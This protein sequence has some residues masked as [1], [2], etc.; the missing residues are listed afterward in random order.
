MK[1]S[2]FRFWT[3][4]VL[5]GL[6]G[7]VAWVVENMYLNVFI[8]KMFSASAADIS[9]MVALSAVSAAVT[10]LFIGALC[11]RIGKLR[12]VIGLGYITWGVTILAFGLIRTDILS[13]FAGSVAAINSLGVT[14]VIV[15]DCLMTFFGSS[16]NDAAYNAWLTE[17]GNENNRGKIEGVNAMMPLIAILV[18][19]GGFMGFNLDMIESWTTIFTIIGITVII[20]GVLCFLLIENPSKTVKTRDGYWSTL[21]YSFRFKAVKQNKLLY[22][23]LVGFALFGIS[24]QTFMPYLI[25]YYEKTLLMNNYVLIM[26][27]AII[28]ASVVTVFY[29]RLYDM[30]G[31]K[32]SIVPA[33]FMLLGGYIILFFTTTTIPVFIGSLLMMCGYL[34]GMAVFGAVIRAEIPENMAG[35]FQGVRII[36][37]VLVPGVIG[38]A[39][40]SAVLKDAEQVLGN[41]GT[42]S[43]IPNRNIWLAATLTLVIVFVYLYF[44]FRF[45]RNAKNP[46]LTDAGKDKKRISVD[47]HPKPQ[48]KRNLFKILRDNWTLNGAPICLPYPPQS[49]L[50]NFKGKIGKKLVYETIF[51]LP[52]NFIMDKTILHFGAVDQICEVF[53]NGKKIG[54]HLDGYLD[55]SFDITPFL[56]KENHLRVICTDKLDKKFP[57]GK[58]SKKRGGMWYTPVS[59]IWQDV[60][61]ENVPTNHIKSISLTPDLKGVKI[62]LSENISSFT[63]SLDGKTRKFSGSTGYLEVENPHF[64]TP[65]D[66]YLY[67]ITVTANEDK[68]ESY[69]ALRK[70]EIKGDKLLLN[71]KPIFLHGVLDQGYYPDGIFLPAENEE[72]LRDIL[73][74]KELGFNTLRKHIKIEP[75]Q[76]YYYC[77]K[78]GML[79]LQD[80]VNSGGYSFFFDTALPTIGLKKR[81]FYFVGAKRRKIFENHI[82]GLVNRLKNHPSIIGYTIFNEGWGQFDAD[83]MYDFVKNLDNTRVI[84]TASGWFKANKTD[85]ESEHIYFKAVPLKKTAKPLLL[86]ECGGYTRSIPDHLMSKYAS[87][88]YGAAETE[89][90]LTEKIIDMY[91]KMVIGSNT[92]GCIYTQLSD[93]EDEINGLYTYDRAVLK[94]N[95]QKMLHLANKL[96]K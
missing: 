9:L 3:A 57:Y 82:E 80:A 28:I 13:P 44:V 25:I 63:V 48:M 2:R 68:I 5:L 10:T 41:D 88:G 6:I 67:E 66:P 18:V 73:R 70:I 78:Y 64:W 30:L 69:F 51:S 12:T 96:Y 94:V 35:R 84:D 38:P 59:G 58:Q 95:K 34:S 15:L 76:F 16:A 20:I 61:L 65:D 29:G 1:K 87:Y 79:V 62:T 86:S 93:V 22:L 42:Y 14:L 92:V 71:G 60:W 52:E 8:Y 85:F 31:F 50:S 37:G 49:P 40:G 7:Q 56:E 39:I 83:K 47:T 23:I 89:E 17:V 33:L 26:A 74:M 91:E 36:G 24:I 90:E 21:I 19:F 54:E 55:F 72:Y 43:F 45:I 46:I 53:L 32:N 11:D 4:L 77:D 75:E 81:P 27:P